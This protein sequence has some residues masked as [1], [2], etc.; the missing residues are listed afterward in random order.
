MMRIFAW[1]GMNQ[2]MSSPVA[3]V[4][5]EGLAGDGSKGRYGSLEHRVAVHLDERGFGPQRR[6]PRRDPGR[7]LEEIFVL[8]IRVHVRCENPG[9][10]AVLE[11]D[12]SC[13]VSEEH[14][15][16]PV[17]PVGDSRQRLCADHERPAGSAG[18]DDPVREIQA[19]DE[20]G[21]GCL[22]I[23]S[24]AAVNVELPLDDARR[25]REYLVRRARRNDEQVDRLRV[26]SGHIKRAS[27][28]G[29][30]HVGRFLTVGSHV[31][32]LDAGALANPF[33]RRFHR[34]CEIRVRD[35]PSRQI[36]AGSGDACVSHRKSRSGFA[37]QEVC[38]G[39]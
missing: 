3:I 5:V 11:D 6:I 24:R 15:R 26:E 30:A 38:N 2:S 31:P 25:A 36:A 9:L 32:A 19:V 27:R 21:T 33:I 7:D 34:L 8:A 17:I 18:L 39:T 4:A 13:T 37:A 14:G 35:D 28:R 12:C 29:K 1:W 16:S 10:I 22:H 23:E 20:S